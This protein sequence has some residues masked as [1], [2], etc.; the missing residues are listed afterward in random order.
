MN[1]K[2]SLSKSIK[3]AKKGHKMSPGMVKHYKKMAGESAY[4]TC[5]ECDL[6]I[7]KYPGRYPKFCPNCG[8]D[9][10]EQ[11][12]FPGKPKEEPKEPV[13]AE[14]AKSCSHCGGDVNASEPYCPAC[15]EKNSKY[16]MHG[17]NAK[18][19]SDGINEM[20]E[21][22]HA[23]DGFSMVPWSP[24][25]RV[26][27]FSHVSDG[28]ANFG[29]C[30]PLK[31]EENRVSGVF[32]IPLFEVTIDEL[33]ER[34]KSIIQET[35]LGLKTITPLRKELVREADQLP[36]NTS[37]GIMTGNPGQQGASGGAAIPTGGSAAELEAGGHMSASSDEPRT[38]VPVTYKQ[39]QMGSSHGPDGEGALSQQMGRTEDDE[40]DESIDSMPWD[41]TS[42]T[43][44]R[45]GVS[46]WNN[47]SG[48]TI[49][50]NKDENENGKPHDDGSSVNDDRVSK[51][52][53]Q[54]EVD[55]KEL[56]F[57]IEREREHTDDIEYAKQIALT[58]LREDPEWYSKLQTVLP[59]S[60]EEVSS[61][62]LNRVFED[63]FGEGDSI[64]KPMTKSKPAPKD[65]KTKPGTSM[66]E[67]EK[68]EMPD[69][70]SP[71]P[72]A[73]SDPG[74]PEDAPEPPEPPEEGD[75]EGED[76]KKAAPPAPDK[77]APPPSGDVKDVDTDDQDAEG[78]EKAPPAPPVKP[79]PDV[80]AVP[81]KDVP[82]PPEGKEPPPE[83]EEA[84]PVPAGQVAPG[85]VA[86]AVDPKTGEPIVD[87]NAQ[88]QVPGQPNGA[89][90]AVDPQTG[91]PIVDP[92]AGAAPAVDPKTGEAPA[93]DPQT[94]EP[95]VDPAAQQPPG[96]QVPGQQVPGQQ[97]VVDPQTGQPVVDPAAQQ[98]PG[99]P[100]VP[101]MPAPT[102][103]KTIDLV[104]GDNDRAVQA[105]EWL[106]ALGIANVFS[107][108]SA[109][110]IQASGDTENSIVQRV[111]SA[112]G[113]ELSGL[114][115]V[116]GGTASVASTQA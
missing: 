29:V 107:D 31:E 11:D 47:D 72:T 9:M 95:I 103:T 46:T 84:P 90:P 52:A 58:H 70:K 32:T 116:S 110:R 17:E 105:V 104:L 10:T 35:A 73:L 24:N 89:A 106:Q 71:K 94:G 20:C 93:V 60:I 111:A 55:S 30:A 101:G 43:V 39:E 51:D 28:Y 113:L 8:T 18:S 13:L 79:D 50:A 44:Q 54:H 64:G 91:E 14:A 74:D 63:L 88:Q 16:K 48:D 112:F 26:V 59:E 5:S 49:T 61:E 6:T 45:E 23:R 115:D 96:Q 7:G 97:P 77:K 83:G 36:R 69:V 82:A 100:G 85:K 109:V 87:P 99:V 53:I 81:G 1:W 21:A 41:T 92:Q 42:S 22:A 98:Q 56:A 2:D 86:P 57:G 114:S 37:H 68:Q 76:G 19:V 33:R 65:P 66:K 38:N 108:G 3:E 4:H 12:S 102:V 67:P 25:H 34:T 80:A 15:G 78:E 40:E 27:H 75:E 62:I